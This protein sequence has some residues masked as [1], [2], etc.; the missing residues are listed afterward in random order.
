MFIRRRKL[1]PQRY[2][3][4]KYRQ[5][6]KGHD[7]S[8]N[9]RSLRVAP[10]TR[11]SWRCPCRNYQYHHLPT[12]T[13]SF[14]QEKKGKLSPFLTDL[15][16]RAAN[17]FFS[18]CQRKIASKIPLLFHQEWFYSP[19]VLTPVEAFDLR[20]SNT[21]MSGPVNC[22]GKVLFEFSCNLTLFLLDSRPRDG[23]ALVRI[24]RVQ[25]Q[26]ALR[27][28]SYVPR[29]T[30]PNVILT[31]FCIKIS[32]VRPRCPRPQPPPHISHSIEANMASCSIFN[33]VSRSSYM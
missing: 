15:L 6:R 13:S 27:P 29:N 24:W 28:L 12:E 8:R 1:D 25:C 17:Q 9:H 18:L 20:S 4:K 3:I 5:L 10:R 33:T 16:E 32:Y 7:T 2:R 19:Q 21:D 23:R 30:I 22:L 14:G 31:N 26:T 11:I